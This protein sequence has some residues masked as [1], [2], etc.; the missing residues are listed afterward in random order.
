MTTAQ[1][2]EAL[3]KGATFDNLVNYAKQNPLQVAG[4]AVT[5]LTCQKRKQERKSPLILTPA[6]SLTI[7][8]TQQAQ[9]PCPTHMDG[10]KSISINGMYLRAA[11]GGMMASG[12]ISDA[13]NTT[14]WL[15]RW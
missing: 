1:R 13:G 9:H 10:S 15:L 14:W 3:K 12:G 8:P 4:M 11:G 5:A 7:K 2:F 6:S